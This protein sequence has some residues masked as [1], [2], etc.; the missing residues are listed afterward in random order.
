MVHVE[1][2]F[3][4]AVG[5]VHMHQYSWRVCVAAW[6]PYK[7][8]NKWMYQL[9]YALIA[10]CINYVRNRSLNRKLCKSYE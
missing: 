2:L 9:L 5:H 7:G 4:D 6:G 8:E 1:L 3:A 10:V